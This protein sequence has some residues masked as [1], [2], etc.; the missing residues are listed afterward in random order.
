MLLSAFLKLDAGAFTTPLGKAVEGVKA[1][2]HIA[3]DLQEH[4]KEAF[5]AGREMKDLQMQ[6]G[7]LPGTLMVLK[8][9]FADTGAGAEM[10]GHSLA[11]MRKSL[12]GISDTGEP[13]GKMF[14]KLGLDIDS[15]G[16]MSATDQ[17]SA[18][19][20]A[21]SD[22]ETPTEQTAAA[23]GIFGRSGAKMLGLLKDPEAIGA[24]SKSLGGLPDM[25]NRSAAAFAKVSVEIDHIKGKGKGM[26]AGIAEG[27][28]PFVS[29]I[30]E[31]LDGVDMSALG[32]KIGSA[33]GVALDIIKV[34]AD[35]FEDY[36][37]KAFDSFNDN[38]TAAFPRWKQGLADIGLTTWDYLKKS[39]KGLEIGAG[40]VIQGLM[41]GFGAQ[42][43]LLPG[44]PLKGFKAQSVAELRDQADYDIDSLV[45]GVKS[46]ATKIVKGATD[47]KARIKEIEDRAN[48]G[49]EKKGKGTLEAIK[50]PKEAKGS[51]VIPTDNLAR[52]GL[53]VG[54]GSAMSRLASLNER[55]AKATESTYQYLQSQGG[56]KLAWS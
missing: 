14:K 54:G 6:T 17:L 22:L 34:T 1:M 4:L 41:E 38:M 53:F 12:G 49:R 26:W 24:A 37:G 18:I 25:M 19:G 31:S 39:V 21:I 23:M 15:L 20:A 46:A 45:G 27:M 44:A 32:R 35:A 2:I 36:F 51:S 11:M 9:A 40:S 29:D 47:W 7:E 30:T 5:D 43:G 28:L 48:L 42:E 8:Q 10:V 50:D 56:F 33:M 13:T 16:K 55:T 3:G 52:I